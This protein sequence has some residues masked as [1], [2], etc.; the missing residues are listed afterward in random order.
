MRTRVEA[1]AV[2]TDDI[3]RMTQRW[4]ATPRG[5]VLGWEFGNSASD[6]VMQPMTANAAD[7]IVAEIKMDMPVL[8][9]IGDSVGIFEVEAEK[10]QRVIVAQV[11]GKIAWVG[12]AA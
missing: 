7:R 8:R 6:A 3:V 5:S 4:F 12:G 11:L 9:Q 2:T 10:N 1:A